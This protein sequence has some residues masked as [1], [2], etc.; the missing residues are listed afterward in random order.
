MQELHLYYDENCNLQFI[1][2]HFCKS[3]VKKHNPLCAK[4]LF[5]CYIA[6]SP[7]TIFAYFLCFSQKMQV[8]GL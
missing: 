8:S 6:Y 3:F 1:T 4:H 2:I 7:K 5:F